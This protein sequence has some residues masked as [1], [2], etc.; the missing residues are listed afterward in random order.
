MITDKAHT[1]DTPPTWVAEIQRLTEASPDTLLA[2]DEKTDSM[3]KKVT[4][5]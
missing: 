4:P 2:V 5:A 1:R 3:S